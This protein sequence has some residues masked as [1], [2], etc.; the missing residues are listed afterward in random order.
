MAAM[1]VV[2]LVSLAVAAVMS[3]VAWRLVREER[4]R[5]DARISALAADIHEQGDTEPAARTANAWDMVPVPFLLAAGVLVL[6][7]ALAVMLTAGSRT[8]AQ[9]AAA[10]A[11]VATAPPLELVSLGHELSGDRLAVRGVVRNPAGSA[12][13][14]QLVAVVLVFNHDG[15]FASSGRAIIDARTLA[16]GGESA[17]TVDVPGVTD[18][19]RYRVSFKVNERIV[20]HI[21]LRGR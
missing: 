13:V 20:E 8:A 4:R 2:T 6:G 12:A 21:D 19:G 9:S 1:V 11:P 15:G 5:S 16:S 18:V 10:A 17:F 7:G 3:L 14:D